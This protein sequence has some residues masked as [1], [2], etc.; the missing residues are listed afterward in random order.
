MPDPSAVENRSERPLAALVVLVSL[1]LVS[2]CTVALGA[3]LALR[4]PAV[5]LLPLELRSSPA[6]D[7][8]AGLIDTLQPLT[9]DIQLAILEDRL[10][11]EAFLQLRPQESPVP[12]HTPLTSTPTPTAP[13]PTEPATASP[14]QGRPP[15]PTKT[16]KPTRT[17]RPTRTPK[18]TATPTATETAQAAPT[19]ETTASPTPTQ[20]LT[21]DGGAAFK[22]IKVPL[23]SDDTHRFLM[24]LSK[25]KHQR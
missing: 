14:T 15:R 9:E 18:A 25:E 11:E 19:P 23:R 24:P 13:Q 22:A 6:F 16:P 20:T 21:Q 17:P 10:L 1:F 7:E 5:I 2:L 3:Q 12:T 4:T 8:L